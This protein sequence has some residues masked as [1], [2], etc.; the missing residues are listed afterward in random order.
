MSLEESNQKSMSATT[1]LLI[2]ILITSFGASFW[3][4]KRNID[5][6]NQM[7][8][9]KSEKMNLENQIIALESDKL[10]FQNQFISLQSQIHDLQDQIN[11]IQSNYDDLIQSYDDLEEKYEIE[12]AL[13]IGNSLES[14]YDFLRQEIGPTGVKNWWNYQTTNYWQTQADF[15]VNLAL[16][17]LRLIYWPSIEGD[18]YEDVGE[19]SYDTA[20][21]K[22][23]QIID[24]IGVD[25]DDPVTIKAKKILDFVYFYIHYETEVNDVFLAPVETLGYKSGD[26]DDF[27][28]PVTSL[29]E[30]VGIDSAIGLFVKDYDQ[31]H[32]MVLIHQHDLEDYPCYYFT[33]LRSMGLNSGHWL[34]IEPQLIIEN[35][36]TNWIEQWNLFVAAPL[37]V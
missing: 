17:D 12:T 27:T 22:I 3:F 9:L 5:L 13:R 33:D 6:Q 8:T 1:I 29:F 14:Y 36:D 10:T 34:I 16:H 28:I 4:Y 35:Q 2:I 11:A 25:E 20:S 23:S 31:Y 21:E 19:Y 18:Y 15:A 7:N 32:A 26:C 30:Y 24:L 37:D